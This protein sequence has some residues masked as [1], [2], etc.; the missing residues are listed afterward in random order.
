MNTILQKASKIVLNQC[1]FC[2]FWI[3]GT[4]LLMINISRTSGLFSYSWRFCW[5]TILDL[6]IFR[7]FLS[8]Y[9]AAAIKIKGYKISS[10]RKKL[11][12]VSTSSILT[13]DKHIKSFCR[14]TSKKIHAL[15]RMLYY[16]SLEKRN[17]YSKPLLLHNS[18]I[19]LL[20]RRAAAEV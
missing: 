18:V 17:S 11:L 14:K 15:S 3:I 16:M 9:E 4:N 13:Y 12:Y 7:F 20:F 10:E 6:Y 8:T 2:N 19:V 5:Y 1:I